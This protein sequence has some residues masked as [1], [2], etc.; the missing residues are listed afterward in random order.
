M[1][2]ELPEFDRKYRA[3]KAGYVGAAVLF[4]LSMLCFILGIAAGSGTTAGVGGI[5]LA[6]AAMAGGF[7]GLY[8]NLSGVWAEQ[9]RRQPNRYGNNSY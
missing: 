8:H 7:T 2:S 4:A 1:A 3:I 6:A 9:E 5:L